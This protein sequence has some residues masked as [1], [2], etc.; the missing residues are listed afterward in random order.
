M[1][2]QASTLPTEPPRYPQ[3]F[4]YLKF[5]KLDLFFFILVLPTSM[6]FADVWLFHSLIGWLTFE[7]ES[8]VDQ[9]CPEHLIFI[10]SLSG[11]PFKGSTH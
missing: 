2:G 1:L 3:L 5:F 10:P 11:T 7:T 4:E 8:D 6:Y 9:A